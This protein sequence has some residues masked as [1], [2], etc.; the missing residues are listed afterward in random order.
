MTFPHAVRPLQDSDTS[1]FLRIPEPE[2]S[3]RG[4]VVASLVEIDREGF[5]PREIGL[6]ADGTPVYVTRVGEYGIWNDSPIPR[7]APGTPEFEEQWGGMGSPIT[8]SEF[9]AVFDQADRT[10]PHTVGGLTPW[11]ERTVSW[12]IILTL[13]AALG[14]CT[15]ALTTFFGAR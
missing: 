14:G 15:Y 9:D 12:A 7:A 11:V 6:A 5:I 2:G 3:G 4:R 8:R 1:V 13:L 10:L